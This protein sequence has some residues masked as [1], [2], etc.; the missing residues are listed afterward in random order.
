MATNGLNYTDRYII[1][2]SKLAFT[3]YARR[4]QEVQKGKVLGVSKSLPGQNA[5]MIS[6]LKNGE[7]N[8]SSQELHKALGKKG[9]PLKYIEQSFIPLLT[10]YSPGDGSVTINLSLPYEYFN[11]LESYTYWVTDPSN[12]TSEPTTVPTMSYTVRVP[13]LINGFSYTIHIRALTTTNVYTETVSLSVVPSTVPSAPTELSATAG[14]GS[15]TVSF[16]PGMDGGLD[17]AKYKYTLNG[18]KAYRDCNPPVTTSP[19][20]ISGLTNGT[21]YSIQLKA[22]NSNGDGHESEPITRTPFAHG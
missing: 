2:S 7:A 11:D 16:T 15:I 8:T 4:Q 6:I 1:A 14:D 21:E 20:L 13:D 18:E 3:D 22:V 5:S 17:I 12:L 10:S 9:P 19:I